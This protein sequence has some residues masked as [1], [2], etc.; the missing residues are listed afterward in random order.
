MT[1]WSIC[2]ANARQLVN[3][4]SATLSDFG[5]ERLDRTHVMMNKFAHG[6]CI[7]C[8]KSCM[9]SKDSNLVTGKIEEMLGDIRTHSPLQR[10][11]DWIH[12]KY[13]TTDRLKIERL[14]GEVLSMEQCYINLAIVVKPKKNTQ[15]A[16]KESD[17]APR[18]SPFSLV[19][20]QNVETPNK[21]KQVDLP[22][23][24]D[25]CKGSNGK[26]MQPRILI[27][28]R[29][30]VG[31]TTLCKKMVHEF[32]TPEFR[33]WNH[34]FHRVLW[35]PLRQLNEWTEPP[36]NLEKLFLKIYFNQNTEK[37]GADLA[38]ALCDDVKRGRTLFIFDGLD[39]ID[40]KWGSEHGMSEFLKD[41]LNQPNVVIT[42]R[43]H[44]S[45]PAN[46]NAPDVELETIGF[47]PHQV[48]DYI[49]A[50]FTDTERK[51]TDTQKIDE[52]QSYLQAHQ[53]IQDLVRIPI[54]LDALCFTWDENFSADNVPQSMTEIFEAISLKLWQKDIHRL[55]RKPESECRTMNIIR[56][57]EVMGKHMNLLGALAFS[58]LYNNILNFDLDYRK[59]IYGYFNLSV[60]ESSV[61]KLS[62]LRTSDPSVGN[63]NRQYHFLHLTFQ[64]YF[65]A[66]YFVQQWKIK[67][68]LCC[69]HLNRGGRTEVETA[70]FLQE[71]KYEP[72]Y[73][74]FWR[75]VAG[76]LSV[77]GEALR[78]FEAVEESRDLLGP[79]HQYLVMHCLSEVRQGD[80]TF[81]AFRTKLEKTLK[82][83]LLFECRLT[84]E[85]YLASEME[86]PEQVLTVALTE[87]SEEE[88]E[89]LLLSLCRRAAIPSIVLHLI[90]PWLDNGASTELKIA[91][92]DFMKHQ[93]KNLPGE[94]LQRI[95]ELLDDE[96]FHIQWEA[97]R[98]LQG[99]ANLADNLSQRIAALLEDMGQ[100]TRRI[101]SEV[102]QFQT[103]FTNQS[104]LR[105]EALVKGE[106]EDVHKA[107]LG[108]M[109]GQA[110]LTEDLLEYMA[111]LLTDKE[112][113][114][115]E[116]A[117][118][119]FRSQTNPTDGLLQRVAALLR[120][121]ED[122]YVQ[123]ALLNMLQHQG[124]LTDDLLQCVKNGLDNEECIVQLAAVKVLQGQTNLTDSLLQRVAEMLQKDKTK[125]VREE[126]VKILQGQTNLTDNL[127]QYVIGALDD[128]DEDIREEA[129]EVLQHQDNLTDDL[130]QHVI[131]AL[132]DEWSHVRWAATR[133]LQGQV[134]LTEDLLKRIARLLKK[135]KNDIRHAAIA[136]FRGRADLTDS[137]LRC[138]AALLKD[139]DHAIQVE[140][141]EVLLCQTTLPLDIL[142]KHKS[143]LF[144]VLVVKSF[145]EH[146]YCSDGSFIGAGSR[147]IPLIGK[148]GDRVS[149]ETLNLRKVWNVPLPKTKGT[150]RS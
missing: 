15:Y 38:H 86:C 70:I 35:L 132:S 69:M 112:F 140:A 121:M 41:L 128:E 7:E 50:A 103:S 135:K 48:K 75:F 34:L 61:G 108:V 96:D 115:R 125:S 106:D 111:Q 100:V 139:G 47:Y 12:D 37:E 105:I 49:Q 22:S 148:W 93:H 141:V 126:A 146:L 56:V 133:V 66:R 39:E 24:F 64:E 116:A 118:R 19:A 60:T 138:I 74:I 77:E 40:G 11:D 54:Q 76:L 63:K 13:Y 16:E 123:E 46:V 120:K 144:Q 119:A 2:L 3:K 45:L 8:K 33:N 107:V 82:R 43:P 78:F 30:G 68:P 53:L 21:E 25:M 109:Q 101:T 127:L 10:A 81:A 73:N 104:L 134:N 142:A 99:Q 147:H 110:N 1:V 20:R 137:L 136:V 94:M 129:L 130:L 55:H 23:L 80:P 114:V 36:F 14:S 58:G 97:V 52:V 42:S 143:S 102:P 90:V 26:K 92:L 88:K 29:A 79:T 89:I 72:R 149:D 85:C 150:P 59:R 67:Q 44:V 91:I 9:E 145:K 124:N 84:K 51:C 117:A 27:R 17:A 131:D 62:F 5:S 83:W 95:G 71:N 4:H 31:K 57:K 113:A 65:A 122:K 28:G 87:A 98:T 32:G 18:S 6:K